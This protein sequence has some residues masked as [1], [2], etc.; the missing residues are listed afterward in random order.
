MIERQE[1]QHL[2]IQDNSRLV[3][4]PDARGV[5][6]VAELR[7]VVAGHAAA[8]GGLADGHRALLHR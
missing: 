6:E 8:G 3:D 1:K 7:H 4:A 5:R 2:P